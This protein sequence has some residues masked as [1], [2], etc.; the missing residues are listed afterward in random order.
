VQ[1]RLIFVSLALISQALGVLRPLFPVKARAA[2]GVESSVKLP[3][4]PN[5]KSPISETW[6][7]RFRRK[8]MRQKIHGLLGLRDRPPSYMRQFQMRFGRY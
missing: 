2:N 8:M 4:A 1:Q 6:F 3:T 5:T 7:H